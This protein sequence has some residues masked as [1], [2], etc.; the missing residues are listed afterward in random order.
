MVQFE[1]TKCRARNMR[2]STLVEHLFC[3]YIE[4]DTKFNKDGLLVCPNCKRPI[5]KPEEL[6]SSGVWF[7]CLNCTTKTSTPKVVF[8][9][10]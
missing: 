7:E 2:K 10:R 3:G 1:C 4:A 8:T 5:R 6:K 9:C